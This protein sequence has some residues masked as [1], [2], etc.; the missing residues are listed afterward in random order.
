MIAAPV[1]RAPD[2]SDTS[3][4]PFILVTDA[5]GYG[6]G[7]CLMQAARGGKDA[8][9][10]P[11]GFWSR[12]FGEVEQ[13]NLATHERELCALMEGLEYFHT[14]ILHWDLEVWCDHRPLEHLLSQ[15][16]LTAKQAR[17]VHRLA[18]YLPFTF[19][20]V[21]GNSPAMGIADALSRKDTDCRMEP[22]SLQE[23]A[24]QLAEAIQDG[25]HPAHST[26]PAVTLNNMVLAPDTP[27]TIPI[28]SCMVLLLCSGSSRSVENYVRERHGDVTIVTLDIDPTCYPTLQGS[29]LDWQ[30]LLDAAGLGG[31][32]WDLIWASPPCRAFSAANTE[33]T[34]EEIIASTKLVQACVDCIRALRDRVCG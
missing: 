11:L 31:V 25:R 9:P 16:H 15:P 21:P 6:M 19:V 30:E 3:A 28:T 7:G 18:P 33:V 12:T 20:Y 1:L 27:Q 2:W 14:V 5:S 4:R 8:T 17:W 26:T 22:K 24:P 29:V 32:Q 34:P 10:H 13:R 23:I